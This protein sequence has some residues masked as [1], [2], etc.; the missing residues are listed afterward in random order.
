MKLNI[1]LFFSGLC[2]IGA[3][4]AIPD[5]EPDVTAQVVA[6][7]EGIADG[8]TAPDR[9]TERGSSYL[10]VPGLPALMK[11]CPRPLMLELLSRNVNGED[12]LYVY[13]AT[14]QP[15]ALRIAIDF[16]KAA[17]I[18]RLELAPEH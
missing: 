11:G 2:C 15:Q 14:C 16:N 5:A 4:A 7:L 10:A 17:R 18:N 3:A 13:R 6:V 1:L 9:F 12:R 8:K